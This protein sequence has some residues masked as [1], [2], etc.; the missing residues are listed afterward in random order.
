MVTKEYD[1]MGCRTTRI[2]FWK[3]NLEIYERD[4]TAYHV[5]GCSI[6]PFANLKQ[7][8]V[9]YTETI[10]TEEHVEVCNFVCHSDLCNRVQSGVVRV[11]PASIFSVITLVLLLIFD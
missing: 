1:D 8:E 7:P 11:Q 2:R 6:I 4:T 3:K 9:K 5:A 10:N